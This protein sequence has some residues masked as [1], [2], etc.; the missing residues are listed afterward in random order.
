MSLFRQKTLCFESAGVL[1]AI[2]ALTATICAP[3]L[4]MALDQLSKAQYEAITEKDVRIPM[5]DGDYLVADV[6]RPKSSEKFPTIICLGMY[7]KDLE[8][9]QYNPKTGHYYPVTGQRETPH[10]QWW[11]PRGYA[12]I[13]VDERGTGKSP[14]NTDMWSIQEARDFYDS[15]EWAARQSWSNGKVGITGVSNYAMTA[16]FV[17]GLQPPHLTAIMPWEGLTDLYRSYYY[18]GGILKWSDAGRARTVA[19]QLHDVS[20]RANN[21]GAFNE[22]SL[23]NVIFH[24]LDSPWWNNEVKARAQYDKIV[25]P[26]YSSGNWNGW[27]GA[28]HLPGNIEGY[29][30]SA[31]PAK[32]KKLEIHIGGHT[33]RFF[34]EEGQTTALRWFDYWLK[35]KDTGIM[36]E[37]PVRLCIRTGLTECTWRFENE[38]P[39][40]RTQYTKFYLSAQ[41]AGVV[42]DSL[43]DG[44][45]AKMAPTR[46]EVVTY[47]AIEAGAVR[48]SVGRPAINFTTEPMVEDTEVTGHVKLAMWVSSTTEDMNIFA[49]LQ[50]LKP[51]GSNDSGFHHNMEPGRSGRLTRGV[52]KASMRKLDPDLSTPYRPW[53]AFNQQ[54]LL[55]PGEVVEVQVDMGA[56]SMV[57][58]KGDRLRLDIYSRGFPEDGGEETHLEGNYCFG[59]NS[60]YLGGKR[61]AYLL[62]PVVPPAGQTP[63]RNGNSR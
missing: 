51:D 5:R 25:V 50:R 15:I 6:F 9:Y 17:A 26:L 23:Y 43:N 62:L 36:E 31:T 20:L 58:K 29:T 42:K 53:H 38:W 47:S 37:P 44:L 39:I 10:W 27:G 14:G 63:T 30:R 35:G 22:N 12:M 59:D 33:E 40:A 60:I 2:F 34:S 19:R 54:Q 18:S 52:L 46:E 7:Q 21:P 48:G 41:K 49:Y 8:T 56:T 28:S 24:H 57:F 3:C 61:A 16:W 11:V 55:K 32:N 4:A 45:L 13:R 1:A